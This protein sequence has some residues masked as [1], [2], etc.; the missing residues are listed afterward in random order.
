MRQVKFTKDWNWNIDGSQS[1]KR[2]NEAGDVIRVGDSMADKLV[3]QWQVAEYQETGPTQTKKMTP[4]KETKQKA[5]YTAEQHGAWFWIKDEDG[6]VIDKVQ[7]VEAK[8]AKLHE[9]NG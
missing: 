3:H 6:D 2:A 4:K 5:T 1:G 8:N 7:G 9:L